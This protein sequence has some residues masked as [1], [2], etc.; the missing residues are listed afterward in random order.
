MSAIAHR[1]VG[2]VK[3][4]LQAGAD[5]NFKE[6]EMT[7]LMTAAV[8][9]S[10]EISQ[11]LIEHGAYV[12]ATSNDG[13][14]A[15]QTAA[16]AGDC[17]TIRVLVA[18]GAEVDAADHLRSTVL[19]TAVTIGKSDVVRCLIELGADVNATAVGGHTALMQSVYTGDLALVQILLDAGADPSLRTECSETA[20]DIAAGMLDA[21]IKDKHI[22]ETRRLLQDRRSGTTPSAKPSPDHSRNCGCSE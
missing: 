13:R 5:A 21:G 11:L 19:M 10:P 22:D 17:A 4:L 6:L 12:N 7:P 16:G 15:I 20:D 2:T 14:T 8:V 1:D 9:K 3:L 18:N